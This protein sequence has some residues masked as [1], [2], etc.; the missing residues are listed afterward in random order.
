MECTFIIRGPA[1]SVVHANFTDFS[2]SKNGPQGDSSEAAIESAL[3]GTAIDVDETYV[4]VSP[5]EVMFSRQLRYQHVIGF[6]PSQVY[7]A[8]NVKRRYYEGAFLHLISERNLLSIVFHGGSNKQKGRGIRVDYH[9]EIIKCGG[10]FTEES[11]FFPLHSAT[12]ET[13]ENCEWVIEAPKG[14]HIQMRLQIYYLSIPPPCSPGE[15][16]IAIYSNDTFSDGQL[17]M[18]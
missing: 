10:V 15:M 18:R 13:A 17:L 3:N 8:K 16:D 2:I 12:G 6:Y 4:D 9:F 1:N 11:G 5:P 14:K 7:L